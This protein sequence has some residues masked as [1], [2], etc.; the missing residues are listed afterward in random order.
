VFEVSL[1]VSI[2]AAIEEIFCCWQSAASK[3]SGRDRSIICR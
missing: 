2:S 1:K 3:A